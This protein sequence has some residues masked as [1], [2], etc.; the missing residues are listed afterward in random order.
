MQAYKCVTTWLVV[1]VFGCAYVYHPVR[2]FLACNNN[3]DNNDSNNNNN[4]KE[5]IYRAP[6]H[7]KHTQLR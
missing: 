4:S 6:F 2:V 1:P 5:C 7:V 3:N